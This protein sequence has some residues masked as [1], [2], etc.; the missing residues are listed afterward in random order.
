MI[1]LWMKKI[2]MLKLETD[3]FPLIIENH[4]FNLGLNLINGK[5]NQN[6]TFFYIF[7]F[8]KFFCRTQVLFVG[9]LIPLFWTSGDVCPGFQN[10]GGFPRLHASSPVHNG[11]LRFTSGVT[12]AFSTNMGVHC[13]SVYTAWLARLF[14]N[15]ING[16]FSQNQTW[17][18][19]H[20]MKPYFLC[21]V[22]RFH[23][24]GIEWKA[25]F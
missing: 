15:L 7:L 10:Q 19:S 16:K 18:D 4:G 23:T 17:M 9:P 14:L 1:S 13:I 25:I 8:F 12:P 11:F 22:S 24:I 3:N 21:F 20:N 6:P 5:F 2:F